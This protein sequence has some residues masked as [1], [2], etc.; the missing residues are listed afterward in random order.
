MATL[1]LSDIVARYG[2][3][4][5]ISLQTMTG[6]FNVDDFTVYDVMSAPHHQFSAEWTPRM[7]EED[8]WTISPTREVMAEQCR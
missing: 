2:S 3:G 7:V 6:D 8:N 1:T 5:V 4:Q